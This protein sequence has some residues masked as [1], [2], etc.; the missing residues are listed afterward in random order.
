M[1][2]QPMSHPPPPSRH[3][4]HRSVAANAT[5]QIQRPRHGSQ[6]RFQLLSLFSGFPVFM[7]TRQ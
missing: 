6:L 7:D 3:F 4:T 1:Q 2:L 5:V